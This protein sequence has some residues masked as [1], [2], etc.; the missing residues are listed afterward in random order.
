MS[1]R[2]NCRVAAYLNIGKDS[3]FERVQDQNSPDVLD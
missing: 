2:I 1:G 3:D